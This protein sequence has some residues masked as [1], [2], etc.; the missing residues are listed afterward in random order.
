MEV[1]REEGEPSQVERDGTGGPETGFPDKEGHDSSPY[2]P[3][4]K[5]D[6]KTQREHSRQGK[7][8]S[9]NKDP[10]KTKCRREGGSHPFTTP[11][12]KNY[13]IN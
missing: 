5:K 1:V 7:I 6:P 11:P 4:R 9:L 10:K 3:P 13:E 8:L 12:Q 2:P